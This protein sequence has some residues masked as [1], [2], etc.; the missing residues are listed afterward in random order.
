MLHQNIS[1][2]KTKEDKRR[3]SAYIESFF[4]HL[5][6]VLENIQVNFQLLSMNFAAVF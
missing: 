2:G 4:D 3:L 1:Q 6:S 5:L